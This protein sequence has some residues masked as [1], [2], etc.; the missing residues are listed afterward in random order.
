MKSGEAMG[1]I[2][3]PRRVVGPAQ[4]PQTTGTGMG[5]APAAT[6]ATRAPGPL[7]DRLKNRPGELL[8]AVGL[9][10]AGL[11]EAARRRL[12]DRIRGQYAAEYLSAP[13]GFLAR[14]HLGPPYVDH[15]LDLFGAIVTHYAPRDTLPDPYGNAR[16]LV[17]NPGY[18]CVEVYSDGLVLP[19]LTN[20]SVV[21]PAALRQ[22]GGA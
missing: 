19:V 3:R 4:D 20:G 11:D 10:D 21:R 9:L 8:E 16:M 12:A 2:E 5:P 13:V 14:C 6:G 1:Y 17:R 18:A 15:I 22:G 7:A